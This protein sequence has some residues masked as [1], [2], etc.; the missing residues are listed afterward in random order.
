M[1]QCPQCKHENRACEVKELPNGRLA[2]A[3]GSHQWPN[4]AV[5]AESLRRANL[6]VVKT[7]HDWTQSL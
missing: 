6:T 1:S 3:C 7:V 5:F 4:S 2:C